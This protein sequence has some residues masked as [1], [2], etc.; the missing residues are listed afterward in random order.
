[1]NPAKRALARAKN[2]ATDHKTALTVALTATATTVVLVAASRAVS[3][4]YSAKVTEFLA[5]K[6]LTDEF[7]ALFDEIN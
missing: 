2:F 3:T 1:M 4:V 7:N 6:G 5:E